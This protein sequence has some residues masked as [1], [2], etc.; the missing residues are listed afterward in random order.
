[1]FSVCVSHS[2]LDIHNTVLFVR[3]I[4]FPKPIKGKIV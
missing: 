1:M 4:Y 2:N 3:K